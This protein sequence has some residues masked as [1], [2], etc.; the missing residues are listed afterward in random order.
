[1]LL[2]DIH[3]HL[4]HP[5]FKENL[6]EVIIKAKDVGLK[7]V[8]L[9]GVNSASNRRILELVKKDSILK[10]ALG[11]YPV[12]LTKMTVNYSEEISKEKI[13]IDQELEFMR[14]NKEKF[15]AF[16][17]VGLDYQETED[18]K[19]QKEG[20]EKIIS[21]A[22]KLKKPIIVHSRKAEE[23]AIN[24]LVSSNAKKVVMHCFHGRKSLVKLGLEHGFHFSIPVNIVRSH[25]FQMITE[26]ANLTQLFTETDAPYLGI[27]RNK[28]NEP[29]NVVYTIKKISEIKKMEQIEVSN[30]IYQNWQ[31]VFE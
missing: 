23:D 13:D 1:M 21:L 14:K 7:A 10:A 30:I 28:Q 27:E 4:D 24:M 15:V 12:E 9:N 29:A 26:M 8:V 5:A 20:F 2:V 16:G 31:R 3:A 25:Q 18:R 6:N 11:F 19:I 17:E 22:E